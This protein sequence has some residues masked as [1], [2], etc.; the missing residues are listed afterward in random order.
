VNG[1]LRSGAVLNSHW[2]CVFQEGYTTVEGL[3]GGKQAVHEGGWWY[4]GKN[5]N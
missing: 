3:G 5:Q 1:A 2:G 4:L